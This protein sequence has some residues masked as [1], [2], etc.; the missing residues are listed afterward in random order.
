MIPPD[1]VSSLSL[2]V[3]HYSRPLQPLTQ[4]ELLGL[5][6]EVKALQERLGISYKDASHRLYMTEIE[7]LKAD[8]TMHKMSATIKGQMQQSLYLFKNA[9]ADADTD[10][11]ADA[12][13]QNS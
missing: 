7:K 4:R 8:E 2:S 12:G 6:A 9:D 13:G 1:P 3:S 5:H 11:D 10:A